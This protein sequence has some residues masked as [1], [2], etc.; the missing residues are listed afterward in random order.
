[1]HQ[2]VYEEIAVKYP[3]AC[4]MA[5]VCEQ[6]IR[7]R[8][9]EDLRR[10]VAVKTNVEI[11]R[12]ALRCHKVFPYL[13][14]LLTTQ[15]GVL[16]FVHL[17]AHIATCF[18][19]EKLSFVQPPEEQWD[20]SDSNSNWLAIITHSSI[21][22]EYAA[23][24]GFGSLS[25]I[26]GLGAPIKQWFLNQLWATVFFNLTP[27]VNAIRAHSPGVRANNVQP[28][29]R[30]ESP[31]NVLSPLHLISQSIKHDYVYSF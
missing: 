25:T 27:F 15:R 23:H 28:Y 21:F 9:N 26:A 19:N 29:M 6:T 7:Q 11:G 31:P 30:S 12:D 3:K 2:V 22:W 10:L 1:M 14:D 24:D 4:G 20:K 13:D 8:V 5:G 16:F 17:C 18:R